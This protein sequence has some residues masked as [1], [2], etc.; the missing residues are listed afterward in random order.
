MASKKHF[1]AV[2]LY[3]CVIRLIFL[4][5]NVDVILVLRMLS[6]KPIN[7]A[8]EPMNEY[9]VVVVVLVL[10]VLSL[11]HRRTAHAARAAAAAA[12]LLSNSKSTSSRAYSGTA[13]FILWLPLRLLIL[14]IWPLPLLFLLSCCLFAFPLRS[15]S[16]SSAR[17]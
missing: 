3:F 17:K 16:I 9:N 5:R 8:N 7:R 4:K 13:A 14:L 1:A 11:E 15:F 12:I 6:L 10:L 2:F